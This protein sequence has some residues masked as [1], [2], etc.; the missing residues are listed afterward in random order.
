MIAPRSTCA[1]SFRRKRSNPPVYSN[2]GPCLSLL[3]NSRPEPRWAKW[4]IWRWQEFCPPSLFISNLWPTSGCPRRYR[5][6][7]MSRSAAPAKLHLLYPMRF[8]KHVLEIDAEA[9]TRRLADWL[10]QAV[11]GKL[12]RRGCV[13]G[14]SGGVDS[15]VVLGLCARAFGPDQVLTLML[16]D[17]D[18]SPESERLARTLAARFGVK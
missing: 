14:I 8:D 4:M 10:R 2:P 17:R 16:P 7:M 11:R 18:S 5:N 13:L 6:R 9:E 3:P 1:S 12:R 15:A